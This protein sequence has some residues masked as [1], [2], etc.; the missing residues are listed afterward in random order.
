MQA[1]SCADFFEDAPDIAS[2]Y[3]IENGATVLC[4]A[5]E[6]KVHGCLRDNLAKLSDPCRKEEVK[7]SI[8]Q[9]SNTELM[10]NLAQACKV[11]VLPLCPITL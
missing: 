9:S 10:P 1:I 3:V 7:L 2:H 8:L 5:G 11:P 6:G 4:P